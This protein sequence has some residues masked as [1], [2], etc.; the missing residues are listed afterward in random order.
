[1]PYT[2]TVWHSGDVVTSEKLNKLEQGVA[3]ATSEEIIDSWLEENI[4]QET[5]YALDRTLTLENA[6]APADLVGDL[7]SALSAVESETKP[8]IDFNWVH[9]GIDNAT[10]ETNNDGVLW[11]SRD[12]NYY[13]VTDLYS[14]TNGSSSLL[15]IIF[16]T[17]SNGA[18]TFASSTNVSAGSTYNFNSGEY[19]RFDLRG[20]LDEAALVSGLRNSK[21]V[22]DVLHLKSDVDNVFDND[23]VTAI[24]PSHAEDGWYAYYSGA[25]NVAGGGQYNGSFAILTIADMPDVVQIGYGKDTTYPSSE[26]VI[27]GMEGTTLPSTG[28]F[29]YKRATINAGTDPTFGPRGFDLSTINDGYFSIEKSKLVTALPTIQAIVINF[30]EG[31]YLLNS[32]GQKPTKYVKFLHIANTVPAL[33]VASDG[34]GDYTTISDAVAAAKDEDTIYIKD[35][36]YT[37][38]VIVNKYLH[39]V[40]QSKQGTILQ[41]NVGDYNNCPL[42]I[43][44]GSVCN[45]TIKS[46]APADASGLSNYA[47]AI[48]L[49]RNFASLAKY[50]KCE[51]YNCDIYSEVNDAIG[52]GTNYAS[53]YDIHDCFIHVAHAPVKSGA[54]GFKCHNG[55][56]QTTGKVTLRNNVIITEDANGGS[57]YDILFHNGGIS[58]TQP[59]EILMV[60]NVLKYYNNSITN[61]FVLSGYNYGNSVPA[62]NTLS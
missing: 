51:I 14:I 24:S 11:R 58:N 46:L 23:G 57:I 54:C 56:N 32:V 20:S 47:Y 25:G 1:M 27:M 8:P 12:E 9:G 55:Q 62:M 41:Q 37:E 5:G 7:K 45:M 22:E 17:E 49:D 6:A 3:D 13:K 2:P 4:S 36:T 43:T 15:W 39:L 19:V 53:E 40:G 60:G 29:Y 16:Y 18:Y 28:L 42:L 50:Q 21:I 59:I 38:T 34:S 48:H 30:P 10:G 35:G 26:H 52:A 61:I 31:T 33:V 44:Q